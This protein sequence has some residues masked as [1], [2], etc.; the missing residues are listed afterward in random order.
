MGIFSRRNHPQ[1][2]DDRIVTSDGGPLRTDDEG[3]S[4]IADRLRTMEWPAPPD[5][6]RERCLEAILSR[7]GNSPDDDEG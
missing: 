2:R 5:G 4:P 6:A 1:A 3:V 7:V